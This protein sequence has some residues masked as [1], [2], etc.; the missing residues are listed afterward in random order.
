MKRRIGFAVLVS[1]MFLSTL[2]CQVS[3]VGFTGVRGSGNVVEETRDVNGF[4]GVALAGSGE[5]TIEVGETESL[6]IEAEDNLMEYLE[7]EVRGGV[8]EIGVEDNVD[9]RPRRPIQFYLTV[10]E[11][12]TIVLSGSGDVIAP[13]LEAERFTTTISGSGRVRMD[14]LDA[15]TLDVTLSG[16]GDMDIADGQ[17]TGQNINVSGSGRYTARNLESERAKV[18][19]VGSGKATVRVSD[20]LRAIIT[21]SGDVDYLGSPT[22]ELSVTGS[23]DVDR[24][25]D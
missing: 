4:T 23:G 9:L 22:V 17:V 20:H 6:R 24:I 3:G 21:G 19:L 10:K 13:D 25:G 14:K 12:D 18:L 5:L 1:V 2:A 8:L 16:S 11:L 7:T 15:D